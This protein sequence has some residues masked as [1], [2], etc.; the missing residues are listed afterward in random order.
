MSKKE[1][2]DIIYEY[3]DGVEYQKHEPAYVINFLP[4]IWERLKSAGE[5]PEGMQYNDL[6]NIAVNAHNNA[7]MQRQMEEA[8]GM[9]RKQTIRV[10][11]TV[12][13][14]KP[15]KKKEEPEDKA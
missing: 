6:Y 1:K 3:L 10:K 8:M 2:E 13:E 11:S 15:L 7:A 12:V 5:I 9:H 4:N 14:T